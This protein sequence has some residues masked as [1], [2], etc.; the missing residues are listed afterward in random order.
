[1]ITPSVEIY[2]VFSIR[3]K[4]KPFFITK[5]ELKILSMISSFS[6]NQCREFSVFGEVPKAT[7]LVYKHKTS[8]CYEIDLTHR[9][10]RKLKFAYNTNRKLCY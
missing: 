3:T 1:M 2:D 10:Q 4:S 9:P 6:L 8:I 7:P 5:S